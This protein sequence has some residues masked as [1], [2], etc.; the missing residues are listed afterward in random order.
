[1]EIDCH[2]SPRR[3][4]TPISMKRARSPESTSPS[5]LDRPP[6]RPV[7]ILNPSTCT[8]YI[9]FYP[10]SSSPGTP[11]RPPLEDWVS[12]AGYLSIDSPFIPETTPERGQPEEDMV[13][14]RILGAKNMRLIY[15]TMDGSQEACCNPGSLQDC[16]MQA[17]SA[18]SPTVASQDQFRSVRVDF[19]YQKR[20]SFPNSACASSTV[21]QVLGSYCETPMTEPPAST[22]EKRKL[23]FALGPRADCELCRRGVNGHSAHW[24]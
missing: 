16:P 19:L 7:M 3:S 10:P 13:I 5:F 6:K 15:Q 12:Q 11:N 20:S 2:P 9:S 1:M 8:E 23:R 17:A 24:I 18:Q 4:L 14:I 21:P 22:M